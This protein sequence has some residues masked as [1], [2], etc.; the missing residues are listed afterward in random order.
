MARPESDDVVKAITAGNYVQAHIWEQALRDAGIRCQ[1]VGDNLTAFIGGIPG[2]PA[3]IWVHRDDLDRAK[4]VL[5]E[6]NADPEVMPEDAGSERDQG[7][8]A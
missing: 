1:V 6:I 2:V 3:E 7:P 5:A 4:E 8:E